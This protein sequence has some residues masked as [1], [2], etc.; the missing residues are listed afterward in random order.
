ML[1]PSVFVYVVAWFAVVLRTNNM[2]CSL[3]Q[4]TT[5]QVLLSKNTMLSLINTT[6]LLFVFSSHHNSIEIK[7][8]RQRLPKG[9]AD[10]LCDDTQPCILLLTLALGHSSTQCQYNKLN[11]H[12]GITAKHVPTFHTFELPRHCDR[13]TFTTYSQQLYF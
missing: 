3:V 1:F 5:L 13:A 2:T 10:L 8:L 7:S 9:H 6:A 4:F 11:E 12:S